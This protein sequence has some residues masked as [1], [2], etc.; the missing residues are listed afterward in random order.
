MINNFSKNKLKYNQGFSLVETL[1]AVLLFSV[2]VVTMLNVLAKGISDTG[3]AKQKISAEYMAQEGIELVRNIRDTHVLYSP[4]PQTGWNAFR[5]SLGSCNGKCYINADNLFVVTPPMQI[6]K[7][8]VIACGQSCPTI[9][10]NSNNGKFGYTTG[11]SSGMLREIRVDPVA[12]TSD[13]IKITST[14]FWNQGSGTY[15]VS[16]TENLYNWLE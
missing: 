15:K 11:T 2:G 1:V 9:L 7:I 8:P 5:A 14:V 4:S 12:G 3:Y 6:T 10:Y 13:E 16:F